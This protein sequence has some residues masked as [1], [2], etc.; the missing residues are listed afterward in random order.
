MSIYHGYRRPISDLHVPGSEDHRHGED[1]ARAT[2][3]DLPP[4]HLRRAQPC[5]VLLGHTRAWIAALPESVRP[6][7]LAGRFARVAN[8]ICAVW[9]DPVA[10]RQYLAGL[11]SDQRGQRHGF[12]S[13]VMHDIEILRA[14]HHEL[15]PATAGHSV[16]ARSLSDGTDH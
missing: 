3:P 9:S 10:G 13:E 16:W 5:L 4:L 15:H 12:P 1:L 8:S 11:F 14:Y 6:H 2:R 7:A